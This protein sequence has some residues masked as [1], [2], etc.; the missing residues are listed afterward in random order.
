MISKTFIVSG[1]TSNIRHSFNHSLYLDNGD[2]KEYGLALVSLEMFCSIPNITKKNNKFKYSTDSGKTWKSITIQK[3]FYTLELLYNEIVS[4]MAMSTVPFKFIHNNAKVSVSVEIKDPNFQINFKDKDTF[5]EV[6]GF[7]YILN[8]GDGFYHNP[9]PIKLF[10][11][12]QIF[13]KTNI[14]DQTYYNSELKPIVYSFFPNCMPGDKLI[15]KPNN[16][17]Y[18]KVIKRNLHEI[19]VEIVDENDNYIDLNGETVYITFH[20]TNFLE[21]RIH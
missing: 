19:H 20:I 3:G 13:I 1:N 12:D 9:L 7:D 14:T 16:L 8:Q 21:R 18:H 15:E 17:I 5:G 2:Q 6:L 4:E 10:P 11:L